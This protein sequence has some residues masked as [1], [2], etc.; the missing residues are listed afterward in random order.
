MPLTKPEI[1]ALKAT[2]ATLTTNTV[3]RSCY[4]AELAWGTKYI[5]PI[6]L[7]E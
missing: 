7:P 5:G 4:I 1:D 3:D 2:A 6:Q